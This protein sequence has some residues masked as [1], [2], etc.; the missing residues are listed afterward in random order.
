VLKSLATTGGL[1]PKVLRYPFTST[2]GKWISNLDHDLNIPQISAKSTERLPDIEVF[3][4]GITK[5]NRK[6]KF[7]AAIGAIAQK[8]GVPVRFESKEPF[9]TLAQKQLVYKSGITSF[10][11]PYRTLTTLF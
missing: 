4:K 6:T 10:Q 3:V 5:S 7:R 11:A 8:L 1:C 9:L 2:T